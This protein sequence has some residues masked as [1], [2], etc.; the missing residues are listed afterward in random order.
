MSNN[1]LIRLKG[2]L[3]ADPEIRK[4]QNG[5]DIATLSIAV[6]DSYFD[7]ETKEF[8]STETQWF[9]AIAFDA[10][11]ISEARHLKKGSLVNAAGRLK[12]SE[13]EDKEGNK[14]TTVEV[15]LSSLE[16][17]VSRK[18]ENGAGQEAAA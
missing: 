4:L 10:L 2:R 5:K 13:Y 6:S 16:E 1:N 9:K 17:V 7:K 18:K 14:R 3:G 15:I 11:E 12:T 8:K